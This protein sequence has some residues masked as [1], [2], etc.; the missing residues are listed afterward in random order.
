M[1]HELGPG[2]VKGSLFLLEVVVSVVVV[3]EEVSDDWDVAT[4]DGGCRVSVVSGTDDGGCRVSVV[5][6]AD[7]CGCL[8]G[9][10]GCVNGRDA[11][12]RGGVAV[13]I[14]HGTRDAEGEEGEL[15]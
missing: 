10:G 5:G 9:G 6:G 13:G 15:Q 4:Y 2:E 7:D 14:S 3:A 8:V 12:L 1:S 11:D